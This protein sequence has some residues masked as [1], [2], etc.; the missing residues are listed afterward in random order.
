VERFF[1]AFTSS[2]QIMAFGLTQSQI[3]ALISLVVAIP[4]MVRTL[5][6]RNRAI[7]AG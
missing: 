1:L 4:L 7:P 3:V 6:L 2:Y 5:V